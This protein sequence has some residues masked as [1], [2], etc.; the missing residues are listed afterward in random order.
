MPVPI[1]IFSIDAVRGRIILNSLKFRGYE[2]LLFNRID[3][4][5]TIISENLPSVVILDLKGFSPGELDYFK[6][7]CT[8]LS[9]TPLIV[10]ANRSEL[11]ALELNEMRTELCKANPLDAELIISKVEALLAQKLESPEKRKTKEKSAEA[12]KYKSQKLEAQKEKEPEDDKIDDEEPGN[13]ES[14]L[15]DDLKKFLD[16]E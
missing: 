9:N 5:E 6:S 1:I 10:L 8:L 16:L 13:E 7:A 15:E 2:A 14:T 3:H 11:D 12:L 4:T